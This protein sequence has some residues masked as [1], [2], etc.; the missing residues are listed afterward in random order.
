MKRVLLWSGKGRS[1]VRL[2]LV[3]GL[4]ATVLVVGAGAGSAAPPSPPAPPATPLLPDPVR[5]GGHGDWFRHVCAAPGGPAAGCG[6]QVVSSSAG[7]PAVSKTPPSSAYGPTQLHTAYS[8]PTTAS[9]PQTIAIVDA[10]D[11]P[12]IES[13]LAVYDAQY[14]LPACTTA[15]GCFKKV[16]QTGGSTYPAGN[17]WHLEIA[18]D[19]ETAHEICQN[20]KILLVEATSN[21]YTDLGA[22]VNEAVAL[23]ANVVSNSYGGGE[24]SSETSYEASYYN[25][26]GVAITASAGDSG[27]GVEFPAA[28]RYVTAVGGTTL[29]LNANGT[30]KSE[31]VW[32]GTGSGCSAYEPKPSWQTDTGC[33]RRTVV[34]VSADADP[35]TGAAVYDSV[36]T[37]GGAA[38]YQVGGTSLAAPLIGAVYALEGNASVNYGST[39][40][41]HAALL[42]DVTSG[43]NGK[44][45]ANASYL[46][47]AIAGFDGPTGLGTPNGGSAFSAGP[48][49]PGF[50]LSAA[51]SSQTIAQ[52]AA[53]GYSLTMAP[54]NGFTDAVA[55]SVAGLPTGA[56]GTFSPTSVGSATTLASTLTVS[57]TASV[58]PGTYPLTISGTNGTLTHTAAA[59]LVVSPPSPSLTASP[60]STTPGGQISA[61][62]ANVASPT[63]SDWIGTFVHGAANSSYLA[64]S[65]TSSCTT[66]AGATAKASGSC[67]ITMPTTTGS[68]D[69]RLFAANGFTL[70]A[71]SAVITVAAGKV[72]PVLST[73]ASAGVTL[74]GSVSDTATLT[75]GNNP[76][77]TVTFN[78]YGPNDSSCTTAPVFSATVAAGAS[79]PS[80]NFNPGSVGT[81]RWIASYSGDGN[82][83]GV[84]AACGA[85]NESV[86]VSAPKLT[87][88]LATN[89]ST[90]ITVGAGTINDTATLTGGSSPTG[91]IT[92]NL[93]GPN[94]STCSGTPAFT[95][96]VTAGATAN[97]SAYTPTAAG[98]YL[99]IASYSGDSANNSV[100]APCGANNESVTVAAKPGP[101]L[102]VSATSVTR[103][104]KVTVSWSGVSSPAVMDWIGVYTPSAANTAYLSWIYDST[105]TTSTGGGSAKASGSCSFTMPSTAGTYQLRLLANNGYTLLATSPNI[106][107]T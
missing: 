90:G 29:N 86:L 98:T 11:D 92:F 16:N 104:G 1:A 7:A 85:T 63:T 51:P 94:N 9:T 14:G 26:P 40:Y 15:N 30:Y 88:A 25:H 41:S 93:Y 75:G 42:H 34:D 22:A 5:D 67:T 52:G 83:N 95:S 54:T 70:L 57:S 32:S 65:Y 21:G 2:S 43:T 46:C 84:T 74:G 36:G 6:A 103:G 24:F 58:A 35:N 60:S 3:L 37:S 55:L 68:Y 50:T 59:T 4:L 79:A 101:S 33:A 89:A 66:S 19:V 96:T 106:T 31:S 72:T 77:G 69:L 17:S 64:Y 78:L 107:T 62:F 91:T 61:A 56:T 81:Y 23:G 8:L 10:Y 39:P 102:T 100:T 105:C 80:G 13:D 27:Y 97:S 18:L 76:T 28:S 53:T 12:T 38:W 20:C 73:T 47:T 87:L 71:S 48:P 45:A 99:W 82:N 44:C 49:T